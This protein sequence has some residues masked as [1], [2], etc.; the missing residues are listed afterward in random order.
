MFVEVF[1]ACDDK[2]QLQEAAFSVWVIPLEGKT[3]SSCK[4]TVFGWICFEMFSNEMQKSLVY[5]IHSDLDSV[6]SA[7]GT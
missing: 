4:V 2:T 5:L 3:R 6:T 7:K 1:G